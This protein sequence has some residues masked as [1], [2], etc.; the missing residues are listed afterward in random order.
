M[1][2]TFLMKCELPKVKPKPQKTRFKW[3][4]D[5][6]K[7]L[8]LEEVHKLIET[9]RKEKE[10]ALRFG[11]KAGVRDWFIVELGLQAGLR[12]DEMA[13]LRCKDLLIGE[14]R[15]SIIVQRGKGGKKRSVK[16][17]S[18]FKKVCQWFLGWKTKMGQDTGDTAY[19][20]TS[21]KGRQLTRRAL[22]KVFKRCIR[23]AGLPEHYSIHC[24]RHTYGSH[25]YKASNHNLRLVQEQLGHSSV[26][27]TEVYVSLMDTDALK[28][29]GRL[30]RKSSI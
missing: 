7:Y 3:V 28:A 26:K 18:G 23:K 8:G 12:V 10:T 24:L 19:V 29:V 27:V 20:F 11:K 5:E 4:L 2:F 17:S 9:C 16:I 25:L 21:S 22:Q 15:S 13:N 6:D 14:N 30:Y 1:K